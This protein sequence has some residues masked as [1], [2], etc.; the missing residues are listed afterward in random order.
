MT[1]AAAHANGHIP[2]PASTSRA[3][4]GLDD[5]AGPDEAERF[6]IPASTGSGTAASWPS[7]PGAALPAGWFLPVPGEAAPPA[8]SGTEP[9]RTETNEP[10]SAGE[11]A[12]PA[13]EAAESA[14]EVTED[15]AGP[16]RYEPDGYWYPSPLPASW[17]VPDAGMWQPARPGQSPEPPTR[18]DPGGPAAPV[19]GPTAALRGR[20]GGPGFA[21]KPEDT[22]ADDDDVASRSGWQ[23]AHGV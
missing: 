22:P 21:V 4:P 14:E 6:G 2:S 20:A 23:L 3:N 7:W 10:K 15:G 18:V 11:A 8:G 1:D 17:Q 5:S 13:A 9:A 16:G 12:E 19:V